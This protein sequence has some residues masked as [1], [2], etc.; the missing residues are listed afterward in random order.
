MN[1]DMSSWESIH[2]GLVATRGG[3]TYRHANAANMAY[4]TNKRR[5]RRRPRRGLQ[6]I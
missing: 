3:M 5:A 2:P 1:M 4:G 6:R